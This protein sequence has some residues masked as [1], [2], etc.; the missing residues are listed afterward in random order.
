MIEYETQDQPKR[1]SKAYVVF[2]I[3]FIISFVSVIFW[4]LL[5]LG[6]CNAVNWRPFNNEAAIAGFVLA[7]IMFYFGAGALIFG[8][9]MFKKRR[10]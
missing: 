1:K 2:K 10:G 6:Y 4:V 5:F 3:L 8:I 9:L 7:A